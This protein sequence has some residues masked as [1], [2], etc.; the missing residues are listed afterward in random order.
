[1]VGHTG[2]WTHASSELAQHYQA[3]AGEWPGR[4]VADPQEPGDCGGR[5]LLARNYWCKLTDRSRCCP[6]PSSVQSIT[7]SS[8]ADG[9][10]SNQGR[11]QR[12]VRGPPCAQPDQVA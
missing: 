1:M 8:V 9:V 4:T 2:L 5:F 12:V 3:L 6:V 10:F 7:Q 11:S